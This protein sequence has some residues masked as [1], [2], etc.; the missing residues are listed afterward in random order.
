MAT[1]NILNTKV[2]FSE[3]TVSPYYDDFDEN[4]NFNRILFRPGHAV[5]ARELTQL[6]TILQ[7]QIERFG[8]HIFQNGS[9]VHGGQSSVYEVVSL[10][11]QPQYA[12][13][14][15]IASRFLNDRVR[16]DSGNNDIE[17][18][19]IGT[20]EAVDVGVPVI[21]LNYIAG[22][23]FSNG[24]NIR[25]MGANV[26]ATIS[27]NATSYVSNGL[28][29]TV[30]EGVFFINGYFVKVP[31]QT[32]IVDPFTRAANAKVGLEINQSIITENSD[33]S[34]LD[35]A[36]ESSNYQAPGAA[37]LKIELDLKA[38]P[39]D[40]QDEESFIELIRIE[41]GLVKRK[42]VY[43]IYSQL[44]DE[45]ARRTYDESGNYTVRPFTI[46]F[47]EH[48]TDEELLNVIISPGKAYVQGY[49]KETIAQEKIP[50]K[51]S[52][53][54]QSRTN[55]D[56][57][58]NYGNLLTVAN[59]KGV[60]D[61]TSLPSVDLHVVPGNRIDTSSY[62]YYRSTLA[63]VAKIRDIEYSSGTGSARK[64]DI[65]LFDLKFFGVNSNGSW[66]TTS[67]SDEGISVIS[68]KDGENKFA[69]HTANAY[70]GATVRI[71]DGI[72]KG[73]KYQITESDYG[74]T[75]AANLNLKLSGTIAAIDATSNLSIE[76]DF[77][78]IKSL[79][80]PDVIPNPPVWSANVAPENIDVR[81]KSF[82]NYPID[83][84][85]VYRMP[86]E[87]IKADSIS[88][89]QYQYI[90]RIASVG[91]VS[92]ISGTIVALDP[93]K[94]AYNETGSASDNFIVV[95][96]SGN[97]YDVT[98]YTLNSTTQQLQL[99][100]DPT[101]TFTG[102]VYAVINL[103]SGNNTK[104]KVKTLITSNTN[105]V[106]TGT[107]DAT[108]HSA[109]TNATTRIYST[110]G[111]AVISNFK[112]IP[113]VK[114]SLYTSDVK[115]ITAIY[116][117]GGTIV[118][119]GDSLLSYEDIKNKFDF[120]TGQKD[121]FYD[122]ATISLKPRVGSVG[123]NIVVCFDWYE[124]YQ[125]ATDDGKGYFSV[126][127]YPNYTTNAGYSDIPS[128]KAENGEVL[129]L[130]DCIDFRPKRTNFSNTEPSSSNPSLEYTL[131]GNRIP[132]AF[133][134]FQMDYDYYLRRNSLLIM[135]SIKDQDSPFLI[136]DGQSSLNPS[137]PTP[138]KDSMV[139][140][141]LQLNPYTATK[142][143]VIT[144]YVENKRY[145]MK[146]IGDLE[147]R[148]QNVEYYTSLSLLEKTATDLV[149]KD[150]NGLERTKNGILVDDFT[151]HGI[152]DVENPDYYIATDKL[153]GAA[154]APQTASIL[155]LTVSS[156]A[157][158]AE[159]E[160]YITLPYYEETFIS[161]PYATKFVPVLA[162]M[163]AQ[164]VG[165]ITMDPP[166]D[167]WVDTT[168]LPDVVLNFNF[169]NGTLTSNTTRTNQA[170][171]NSKQRIAN[172]RI[173]GIGFGRWVDMNDGDEGSINT[174]VNWERIFQEYID[175]FRGSHTP[176]T[177][178]AG[179]WNSWF[180]STL[181]R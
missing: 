1:A 151:H 111:Q 15:V 94:E 33:D 23:G 147:L 88:N 164:F 96:A 107:L 175:N 98:A 21:S 134:N 170:N 76:F 179:F 79:A 75:V 38:R 117:T 152:G 132:K 20:K 135:A 60:L 102:T 90:K 166:S 43:P 120:D 64:H 63:G 44:G 7:N 65:S 133:T 85:L 81:N 24:T 138:I 181:R 127:S 6:Q 48:P 100:V 159:G 118:S 176:L 62:A 67:T 106:S 59:T 36:Q 69:T 51:R 27:S 3:T 125:G 25:A 57:A 80:D 108:L 9:I 12:A 86:N 157:S 178:I 35:P 50:I 105:Y 156:K 172:T 130:R 101:S 154:T 180:G 104:Q 40:T 78:N 177:Q 52:R 11:L 72:G 155:P 139:L 115:R 97:H 26:Y 119:A 58:I 121:T 174:G 89:Q 163:F 99:F 141:K 167:Y 122:H 126:D 114:H 83:N 66:T 158:V 123:T 128:Y 140:F 73:S 113:G 109:S 18:V 169:E 153:Y 92:G 61:Y 142:N 5:Q 47:E 160:K 32:I 4:K 84:R 2:V 165:K 77:S 145:T 162:Y 82:L 54:T 150:V 129:P 46:T 87:Y 71:V 28:A 56:L 8:S 16:Y 29:A 95:D 31:S 10:N 143:D 30:N 55:F 173:R 131:V 110:D 161:Q 149:I 41:N 49:E 74:V 42:A 37:R 168:R 19:V 53:E 34:L 68:L 17:G 146:D 137:F 116:D 103:N 39:L 14:D 91:F 22:E 112:A 148:I 136:L 70:T 124:H 171:S 144:E 93:E 45:L 13:T